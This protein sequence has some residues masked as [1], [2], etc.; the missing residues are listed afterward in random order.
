MPFFL[1]I[2]LFYVVNTFVLEPFSSSLLGLNVAVMLL[3]Y[4]LKQS[5]LRQ[6]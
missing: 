3:D 5:H 6:V 4:H 1:R 2:Y